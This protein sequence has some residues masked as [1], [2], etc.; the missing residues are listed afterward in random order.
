MAGETAGDFMYIRGNMW[1][2]AASPGQQRVSVVCCRGA[3][4]RLEGNGWKNKRD[5][6]IKGAGWPEEVSQTPDDPRQRFWSLYLI[7][8]I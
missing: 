4:T 8:L 3:D 6:A 7:S 1:Q 5:E 2:S